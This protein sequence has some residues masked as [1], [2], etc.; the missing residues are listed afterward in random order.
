MKLDE[1]S[2]EQTARAVYLMNPFAREKYD[3]WLELEEFMRWMA[4]KYSEDSNSFGTG[5]FQLTAF[6]QRDGERCVHASVQAYTALKFAESH[7][8]KNA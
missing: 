8:V 6:D 1:H 7:A 2:F 4:Y 5:G 3:N